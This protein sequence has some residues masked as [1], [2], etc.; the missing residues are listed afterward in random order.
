MDIDEHTSNQN[1]KSNQSNVGQQKQ[2]QKQ[3][4]QQSEQKKNDNNNQNESKGKA[5]GNGD[6]GDPSE[7]QQQPS[8]S[9]NDSEAKEFDVDGAIG[10]IKAKFG[11]NFSQFEKAC[12]KDGDAHVQLLNGFGFGGNDGYDATQMLLIKIEVESIVAKRNQLNGM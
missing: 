6:I 3:K 7:Q 2:K 1:D 10:K 5:S 8:N 11:K 9:G 4:Q 12:C